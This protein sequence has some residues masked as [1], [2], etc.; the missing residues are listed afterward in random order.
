MEKL[1][2]NKYFYLLGPCLWR[3]YVRNSPSYII[4]TMNVYNLAKYFDYVTFFLMSLMTKF[5]LKFHKNI[6]LHKLQEHFQKVIRLKSFDQ[7]RRSNL[8]LPGLLHL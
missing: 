3:N 1:Q 4:Q 8:L 5:T 6:R 7:S 2:L